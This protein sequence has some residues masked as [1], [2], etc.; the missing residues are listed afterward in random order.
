[1]KLPIS[2]ASFRRKL[3]IAAAAL[4]LTAAS[5]RPASACFFSCWRYFGLI[6]VQDGEV[7][8]YYGCQDM[9]GVTYCYYTDALN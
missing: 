9:D 2:L 8:Y 4:A 5:A 6:V 7:Y 3:T 1:M